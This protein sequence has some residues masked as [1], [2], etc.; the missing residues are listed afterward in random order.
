MCAR[1]LRQQFNDD[2]IQHTGAKTPVIYLQPTQVS[3]H[4]Y[5]RKPRLILPQFEQT[6]FGTTFFFGYNGVNIHCQMELF[7]AC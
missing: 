4:I 7:C 5:V 1:Q 2:G 3:L 6:N